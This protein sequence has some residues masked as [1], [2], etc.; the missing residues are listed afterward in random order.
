MLVQRINNPASSKRTY[1]VYC[2]DLGKKA[3]FTV[4]SFNGR[5]MFMGMSFSFFVS[6]QVFRYISGD[7]IYLS[8]ELDERVMVVVA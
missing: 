7:T 3:L 2:L 1:E 8:F 4:N 5:A 6:S